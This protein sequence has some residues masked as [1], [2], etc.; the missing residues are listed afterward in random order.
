[1]MVR[2][3]ICVEITD[4]EITSVLNN[5]INELKM[6]KGVRTV[7]SS[8]LHLTLKFLGEI[9]E[10]QLV[11]VQDS[12][13]E[14]KFPSFEIA[15]EKFGVFP[16]INRIR[17]IWV[18]ISDGNEKLKE[19]A[20]LIEESLQPLGFFKEK[21]PFS[22]HL[23]LARVKYLKSDEKKTLVHIIKNAER[24]GTQYIDE[25]ILKKSALTPNG[26]IYDNLLVVP[27]SNL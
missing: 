2:S 5:Y 12:I 23:T 7:K 6:V 21:R 22:P 18:G 13:K 9:S 20:H 10:K 25:V 11:S 4:Q 19:L 8:Q 3:F 1:M 15:L 16:N 26:A 27:L 24:I 14:I 17:V